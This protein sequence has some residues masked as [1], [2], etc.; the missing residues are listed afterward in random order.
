MTKR[1][2]CELSSQ[3]EEHICYLSSYRH[4]ACI[5]EKEFL[6][7]LQIEVR[8]RSSSRPCS[9]NGCPKSLRFIERVEFGYHASTCFIVSPST[10]LYFYKGLVSHRKFTHF[11]PHS[12]LWMGQASCILRIDSQP[13]TFA[14][15]FTSQDINKCF[16]A[17]GSFFIIFP[18]FIITFSDY[19]LWPA[20]SIIGAALSIFFM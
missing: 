16:L 10:W 6:C 2:L 1:D 9:M 8:Y 4:G 14:F 19:L 13:A 12:I 11:T 18:R 5:H 20:H 3:T 15:K 7:S 17:N